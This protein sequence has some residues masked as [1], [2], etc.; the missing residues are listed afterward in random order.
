LNVPEIDK[1]LGMEVYATKTEGVGGVI[2][3]A[4]EDFVVEE[5]LVD[6]SK[7]TIEG[8]PDK[9]VLGA[10]PSPR[11]YLLCVLVKRNWD[12]FITLKNIAKQLDLSQGQIHIAGIK[13]AKAVTA[14]HITLEDCS[15][16]DAA[17]VNVK[18]I[19]IRPIGY[20]HEK[21]SSYYLLGNHFTI[22]VKAIE[23]PESTVAER[24]AEVAEEVDAVGGIPN[25]FGHQRFGTTRPI[26]HLVGKA[27]LEGA[28]EE[29]A[30]LF[31]AKPGVHE[32]P[33]SRNARTELQSTRD[34][35]QALQNFPSQLRFERLM[36][37]HL[38]ENPSDFAGAFMRL[39]V[40]LQ[41]LFV[42]ASQSYLFNRFL[43]ERIKSGFSLN[44][45]EVGDYV[46]NV[47]RSGLPMVNVAKVATEE[48][49]SETNER[50]KAGK[51]RVALPLIG[52]KQKPSQ[53]AMGEIE[54]LILEE[55][56]VRAE[57]FRVNEI[58]RVSGRGGLRAVLTPVQGFKLNGTSTSA[59]DQN[60]RHADLSFMLL[61]GSYATV[62]LREVMKPENPVKAGF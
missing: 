61:R 29:A 50:L 27:L 31:L 12:T 19:K 57:S 9:Q 53:G 43:S 24:I 11:R 44:K 55:E 38:A 2:R 48:T 41:A 7:A 52:I 5:V 16:E 14:Q 47:E 20:V 25:F 15:I 18:D 4:V 32:H 49:V 35:K 46:V 3:D 8:S 22:R 60:G 58:S 56:D 30:M 42:Q 1:Q 23:Q 39:P 54:R 37:R 13:D 51:I 36:L 45:A 34:F 10:S 21:L 17:K 59:P 28:F 6:G 26:T 33:D 62:F 40:K